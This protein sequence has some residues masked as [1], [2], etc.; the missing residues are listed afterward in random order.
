MSADPRDG[1]RR[2]QD[3]SSR[4][5]IGAV[6]VLLVS[7]VALV[8]TSPAIV[9]STLTVTR[10]QSVE[11]TADAPRAVGRLQLSLSPE[12]L[13]V[14]DDSLRRV[15]GAV[16]F[17]P[18]TADDDEVVLDVRPIGLD[19]IPHDEYGALTF[20]IEQL[21]RVAEPCEVAFEVTIE[22][23]A[24]RD[25]ARMP[26]SH[27][28]G[29]EI[30]FHDVEENP[31]GATAAWTELTALS[32]SPPGPIATASTDREQIV[33][34]D[35]RWVAARHVVLTSSAVAR[36]GELLALVDWGVTQAEVHQVR[37]SVD[38]DAAGLDPRSGDSFDPFEDCPSNG[39]CERGLTV[40]FE[41]DGA[42]AGTTAVVSW[43]IELRAGF[44]G[45]DDVPDA[46]VLTATVD[47]Q[48]EATADDPTDTEH[49]AGVVDLIGPD[50]EVAP[51]AGVEIR[52]A[53]LT[54]TIRANQASLPPDGFDGLPPTG[55]A[56]I[57]VTAPVRAS[58]DVQV[59]GA[60]GVEMGV[61]GKLSPA[62]PSAS[63]VFN[64]IAS[65][66]LSRQC[67][68]VV[69]ITVTTTGAANAATEVTAV[70]WD[71]TVLVAY[72][73]LES[74]PAQGE[75]DMSVQPASD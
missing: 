22:W 68:R 15:S 64:P 40:R 32:P 62:R 34:D 31:T 20:P 27:T 45:L 75:L 71:L 44:P 28:A 58:V 55:R 50:A 53:A 69:T 37:V 1:V 70:D 14:R 25:G 29:V 35:E 46:A 66:R 61:S 19:A 51:A 26:V 2:L 6:V 56:I 60:G 10:S 73:G 7:A 5:R 49:L 43:S 74:L 47:G 9:E 48:A 12:A 8:A 24:P 63:L 52:R 57:T 72:P 38:L 36:D 30:L 67:S 21:C 54:V 41:L 65:C 11:L 42:P 16:R 59:T 39:E 18:S 13:P 3:S 23:L 33:L 17:D 4:R